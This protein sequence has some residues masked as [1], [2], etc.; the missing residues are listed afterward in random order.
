MCKNYIFLCMICHTIIA[1]VLLIYKRALSNQDFW[2][3]NDF[4]SLVV[5]PATS[6]GQ[7]FGQ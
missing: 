2:N 7:F 4:A 3:I 6:Q 1:K 5:K